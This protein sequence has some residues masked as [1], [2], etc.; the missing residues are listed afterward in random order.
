VDHSGINSIIMRTRSR[1]WIIQGAKVATKIKNKC[2]RCRILWKLLQKK[3]M[4]PMP[5]FRLCPQ[6]GFSTT[7][8]DLFGPLEYKDMVKKQTTSKGWGFIFVCTVSSSIHLGLTV[9]YS[10]N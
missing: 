3:N 2:Y 1:V 4:F 5:D 8:M 6:E 10:T 9:S 7:A